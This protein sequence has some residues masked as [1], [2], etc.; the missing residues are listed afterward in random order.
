M[1]AIQLHYP[2][3]VYTTDI[4]LRL[5]KPLQSHLGTPIPFHL[6]TPIPFHLGTPIP[7]HLGTHIPFHLHL[8]LATYRRPHPSINPLQKADISKLTSQPSRPHLF[9]PHYPPRSLVPPFD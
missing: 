9:L 7:F 8:I 3:D 5:D 6:G 2:E 4:P 1:W